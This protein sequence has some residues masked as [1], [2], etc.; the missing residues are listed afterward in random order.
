MVTEIPR[1]TV[2]G[3]RIGVQ[4]TDEA[5]H[6]FDA[7]RA[8]AG[9]TCAI[10]ARCSIIRSHRPIRHAINRSS[11]AGSSAQCPRASAR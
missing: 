10:S 1:G 9:S 4:P 7:K 6:F 8:A 3:K 2:I 11:V 5:E